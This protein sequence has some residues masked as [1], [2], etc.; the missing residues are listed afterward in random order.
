M[1]A[2]AEGKL[3]SKY[4]VFFIKELKALERLGQKQDG[5]PSTLLLIP[6]GEY[7]CSQGKKTGQIQLCQYTA[8]V[9]INSSLECSR[10]RFR[11]R[12]KQN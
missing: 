7:S 1:A 3:P 11:T 9:A 12:V 4:N 6:V 2:Y 5:E 10:E 8:R